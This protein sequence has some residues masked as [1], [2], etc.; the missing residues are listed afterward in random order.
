M[1]GDIAMITTCSLFKLFLKYIFSRSA[2]LNQWFAT[3]FDPDLFLVTLYMCQHV[4]RPCFKKYFVGTYWSQ[5][6]KYLKRTDS[7][8]SICFGLTW[9]RQE[10]LSCVVGYISSSLGLS[11]TVKSNKFLE[12]T[13]SHGLEFRKIN[14]WKCKM[15]W[16]LLYLLS[17][18]TRFRIQLGLLN[19]SFINFFPNYLSYPLIL[20]F[21]TLT[22]TRTCQNYLSCDT[23]YI[24]FSDYI[25]VLR[26]NIDKSWSI[27]L[28][29]IV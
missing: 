5:K 24:I 23:F 12:G 22:S 10:T 2:C 21:V 13:L 1:S 3:R 17:P 18:V 6:P 7:K 4:M 27:K 19:Q 26:Q 16:A 9:N 8:R 14:V 15:P 29:S 20:A 11:F 25:G 28:A